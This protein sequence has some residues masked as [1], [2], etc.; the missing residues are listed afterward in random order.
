[1][2]MNSKELKEQSRENINKQIGL[3]EKIERSEKAIEA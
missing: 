2:R 3:I 1:M